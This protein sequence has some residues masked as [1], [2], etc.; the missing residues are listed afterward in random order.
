MGE[1]VGR[2]D[3]EVVEGIGIVGDADHIGNLV[4]LP[5]DDFDA[6]VTGKEGA[7]SFLQRFHEAVFDNFFFKIVGDV[8]DKAVAGEGNDL[9]VVEPSGQGDWVDGLFHLFQGHVKDLLVSHSEESP[10]NRSIQ[11][12]LL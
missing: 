2:T 3:D 11:I 5:G 4:H 7:E 1:F 9:C 12:L 10:F 6:D 8:E